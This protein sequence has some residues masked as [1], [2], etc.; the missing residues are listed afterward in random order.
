MTRRASPFDQSHKDLGRDSMQQ[1]RR[2]ERHPKSVLVVIPC[3]NEEDHIECIVTRLAVDKDGLLSRI[4]VVD[5]GS[6]DRTRAI[7]KRL[8]ESNP[9]IALMHNS[10]RIQAA[11]VNAAVREYGNEA[12]FLVRIDAHA[13]YPNRYCERLLKVQGRTRADSVVVSM[14]TEGHS[15]FQRAAAAAQNS[16]LGN[17]GSAH[18]NETTG[19]WVDH[20]HHALMT[21][22]AFSA[23]GGYDETFSHNEDAELDARLTAAGFRIY[24]TGEAQVRYF[25][26]G[27]ASALFQ[28]YF[29]IGKGRARNFFKHRK[30]VRIRHLMLVGVVPAICLLLLAPF[31]V[32]FA[33]PALAWA[34]LCIGYGVVLGMGLRDACAAAAG[35]AAIAMQA[36]WSFGFFAGLKVELS[37]ANTAGPRDDA[38]RE[39]LRSDRMVP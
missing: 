33:L 29:N 12:R 19:C 18:R 17:G 11:A 31:S 22:A 14:H 26:R 23:V 5:G 16:I 6:T 36:G 32:V 20:G 28:Q 3:L 35:I 38:T 9:R 30:D 4:V 39:T 7:V 2:S 25:P 27:A 21:I 15:C 34:L 24:L 13:D 1:P 37:R 10:K 8:A